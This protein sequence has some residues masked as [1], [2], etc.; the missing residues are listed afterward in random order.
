MV[1]NTICPVFLLYSSLMT[2]IKNQGIARKTY[3]RL[4]DI[5]YMAIFYK[6]SRIALFKRKMAIYM[7]SDNK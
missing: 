4:S 1:F 3:F 6:A 7:I 2:G 5:E